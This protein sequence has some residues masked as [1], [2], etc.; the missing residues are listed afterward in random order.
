M[1]SLLMNVRALLAP[2]RPMRLT[3]HGADWGRMMRIASLSS[4]CRPDIGLGCTSLSACDRSVRRTARPDGSAVLRVL[5][6]CPDSTK[7][8]KLKI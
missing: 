1:L 5:S 6:A 7:C 2:E 3:T 8:V 4:S